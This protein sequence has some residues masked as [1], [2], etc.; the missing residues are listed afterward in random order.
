MSDE[1]VLICDDVSDRRSH[2]KDDLSKIEAIEGW[3][4]DLLAEDF[5]A[6]IDVLKTRQV[7]ARTGGQNESTGEASDAEHSDAPSKFDSASILLVDY[8]LLRFEDNPYLTGE[9]VA[10]L[11]RCYSS[12]D[13][14]VGVNLTGQSN[15]FDL[16]LVDHLDSFADVNIGDAQLA[17]SALWEGPEIGL[18]PWAWQSLPRLVDSYRQ[19]LKDVGDGSGKVLDALGLQQLPLPRHIRQRIEAN[20]EGDPTFREFVCRSELGLRGDDEP[21]KET[22]RRVGAA[23]AAKWLE[24][25]VL[26]AQDLLIDAPHLA[27][28]NPLLLEGQHGDIAAWQRTTD[29]K[30][31]TGG[32]IEE[33][34]RHRHTKPLWSSRP[35]WHWAQVSGDEDLPGVASPW[36]RP[37]PGFVFCEDI[38]GFLPW[39]HARE[40]IVDDIPTSVPTRYVTKVTEPNV[41][42]TL[43]EALAEVQYLPRTRLAL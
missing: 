24:T 10:Y 2:W 20:G 17:S 19:R 22:I 43:R 16:T 11:A 4:I 28:R 18:T 40:F 25:Q 9:N 27:Q 32:L 12:C 39:D 33:L 35:L 6:E 21:W 37:S 3:K 34:S 13:V 38:S 42:E 36:D 15:A 1:T 30:D 14:I 5:D 29:R 8:D 7:A 31:L 26:P 23:R 41:D